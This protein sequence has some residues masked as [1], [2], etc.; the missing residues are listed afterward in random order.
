MA[1]RLVIDGEPQVPPPDSKP[2]VSQTVID[3]TFLLRGIEVSK[4]VQDYLSGNYNNIEI[5]S[6]KVNSTVRGVVADYSVGTDARSEIYEYIDRSGQ[7]KRVITINHSNYDKI[8]SKLVN[9]SYMET[10]ERDESS[11]NNRTIG[12]LPPGGICLWCRRKFDFYPVGTPVKIEYLEEGNKTIYHTIGTYCTYECCFSTLKLKTRCPFTYRDYRY[13]DS[14]SMLR[15]MYERVHPGEHL[16]DQNDWM[17]AQW[18]GGPLSEDDFFSK[19]HIYRRD[20][21]LVLL[22]A[23]YEYSLQSVARTS[24]VN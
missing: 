14:E 10:L 19:S 9:N 5:P 11:S 4:V 3:P 1:V 16:K 6:A 23:K 15:S 18:N 20:L 13:M 22:P 7:R 24:N 2:E 17:L 8:N 21:S 12:D